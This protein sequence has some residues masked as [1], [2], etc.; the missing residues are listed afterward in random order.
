MEPVGSS[1]LCGPSSV[2]EELLV[3]AAGVN[4]PSP[5][6]VSSPQTTP[7]NSCHV[8]G[9]AWARGWGKGWRCV[10]AGGG[11]GVHQGTFSRGQLAKSPLRA[12]EG[13]R[14]GLHG[15]LELPFVRLIVGFVM[16]TWK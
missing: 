7:Q 8:W 10:L 11:D 3:Q 15:L 12:A 6:G 13:H 9:R 1:R 16:E 5:W 2:L 4:V 14:N